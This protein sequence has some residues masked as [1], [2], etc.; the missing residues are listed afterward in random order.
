MSSKARADVE[1]RR[2]KIYE[3]HMMGWNTIQIAKSL[4]IDD[5]NVSRALSVMRSRHG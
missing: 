5:S 4:G 1:E 2:L 3:L